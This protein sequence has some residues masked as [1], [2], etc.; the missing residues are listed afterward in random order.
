MPPAAR[1]HLLFVGL[2]GA[3]KSTVGR[4]V[5]AR[6]GVPF[7]DLDEEIARAA[8]K[9]VPDIFALD[10]EAT[11]RRLERDATEWLAT[12]SSRV[13]APGGGWMTQPGVVALVRPPGRIIHLRVSPSLAL[14]R[15]GGGVAQRPLLSHPDP[16]AALEA[17][18]EAR[19]D[20]YA[21]ADA[22]LDTETLTLQELVSQ[23]AALA[24][25]WRL[26]VG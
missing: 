6:L 22:V 16:L 19:G 5:A 9:S 26:G 1:A 4:L 25:L 13:V 12:Q 17:L 21:T 11:F 2:P 7:V 18:W 24:T 23:S 20:A 8:G 14:A 3:G 15:M 10:G